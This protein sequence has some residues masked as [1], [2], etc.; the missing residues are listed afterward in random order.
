M[1][2]IERYQHNGW[3]IVIDTD[4]NPMSPRDADN[5][6]VM[7]CWHPN[8]TLGDDTDEAKAIK[9][10]IDGHDW[11]T[12][13]RNAAIQRYL[14]IFHGATAVQPLYLLD[15]SGLSISTRMFWTDPGGWDTSVVGFVF[16]TQLRR[17]VCGTEP[18][19]AREI[20][21]AEVKAYDNYLTGGYVGFTVLNARGEV[22]ESLWGIDNLADAKAEAEA[23][24]P[25]HPDR[26]ITDA[27]ALDDIARLIGAGMVTDLRV[28]NII[29]N[30]GRKFTA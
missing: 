24:C 23:A 5:A 28:P 26:S 12:G 6:T 8:Y 10:R 2:Q 22:V 21:A 30:T 4:D 15:H 25:S 29:A 20:I 18:E 14:R 1:T 19:N 17:E 27:Q 9:A 11:T 7:V 3:T 13:K 16:D